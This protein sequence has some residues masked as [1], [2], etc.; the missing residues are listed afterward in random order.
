MDLS[1][2]F[3]IPQAH[4]VDVSVEAKR[5]KLSFITDILPVCLQHPCGNLREQVKPL[6]F[7]DGLLP[8]QLQHYGTHQVPFIL[9]LKGAFVL[10]ADRSEVKYNIQTVH[11]MHELQR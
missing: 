4:S 8:Q 3:V 6:L 5:E 7:G 11:G 10:E 1:W 9:K 2:T